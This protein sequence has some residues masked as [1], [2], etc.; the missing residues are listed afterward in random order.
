M[1]VDIIFR[2]GIAYTLATAGIVG[3]YFGLIAVFADFF[4]PTLPPINSRGTWVMA[5]VLTAILF[6]PVVNYIQQWVDRFFNRE[7]YDYR[8]TLLQF[9]RELTSELHVDSLLGADYP[10]GCRKRWESTGLPSSWL[11]T[12]MAFAWFAHAA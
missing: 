2:R 3:L 5:I 11:R 1:D 10:I 6:Q 7:R 8:R 4:R 9:A 12:R